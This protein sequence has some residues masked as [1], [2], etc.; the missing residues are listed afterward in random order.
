MSVSLVCVPVYLFL[1]MT[2]VW[3]LNRW[4]K[5]TA[6]V[7]VFWGIG[8]VVAGWITLWPVTQNARI[9][10][11]A[12]LLLIWG[13]RLSSYLW[14]TRLRLHQHDKRYALIE[15]NTYLH[16]LFQ[17]FLIWVITLMFA[18]VETAMVDT[19][20]WMDVLA[21]AVIIVGIVCESIADAQLLNFKKT[22]PNKVCNYGWWRLSR[23]PNLFFDWL[24]WVGF[25]MVC[26]QS[27]YGWLGL[28]SPLCLY[29]VMNKLTM[30]ITERYSLE[31][32]GDAYRDYQK[33]TS[34]FFPC[35]P[36]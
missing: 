21:Y 1:Q 14:F 20:S 3:L 5:N 36:H 24:V 32:K 31:A 16:F 13:L 26:A 15:K 30:P 8:L 9:F 12:I 19:I 11:T 25:Y 4:L 6:I 34:P 2:G 33:N 7:D 10:I 28:I 35:W 27:A 22:F 17:G 18:L 29:L 23:H